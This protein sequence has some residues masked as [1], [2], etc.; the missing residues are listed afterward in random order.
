MGVLRAAE[1]RLR[2]L[3]TQAAARAEYDALPK[4][5]D[6][7]KQLNT[8]LLGAPGVPTAELEDQAV[9]FGRDEE[10]PERKTAAIVV[11]RAAPRGGR[12]PSP[13]PAATRKSPDT[14][15]KKKDEYPKFRRDGETLVK[16][17][18]SKSDRSTYEHRAPRRVIKVLVAALNR[19]GDKGT[20][21][22][23]DSVLPLRDPDEKTDI[24]DYQVYLALAW[25]RATKLLTQH[26][27]QGYSLL[28]EQDLV[29]ESER[30]WGTLPT[31]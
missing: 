10:K 28:P 6:W 17:G 29:Q 7:A 15:R 12:A 16:I 1:Q 14:R 19:V 4:L 27:R 25:L 24:P 2:D 18:W 8:L 11:A 26:G 22:T 30:L 20:R 21:F 9:E 3:I 31:R 13:P 23:M 5:A